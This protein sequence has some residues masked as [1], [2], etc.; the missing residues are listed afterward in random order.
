MSHYKL[1]N[2]SK[3]PPTILY[4]TIKFPT[5]GITGGLRPRSLYVRLAKNRS[6]RIVK[7]NGLRTTR[8]DG[9]RKNEI[10][11]DSERPLSKNAIVET[12]TL[13]S[14]RDQSIKEH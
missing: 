12:P 14:S 9:T 2:M 11:G 8:D 4:I 7:S 6:A 13:V 10:L 5:S 3:M 1:D